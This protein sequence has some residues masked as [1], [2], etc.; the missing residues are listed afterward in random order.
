MAYTP[1]LGVTSPVNY[2]E[3]LANG[4]ASN[5]EAQQLAGEAVSRMAQGGFPIS[6]SPATPTSAGVAGQTLAC[7]GGFFFVWQDATHVK[8]VGIVNPSTP[9]AGDYGAF[10]AQNLV[11]YS[12]NHTIGDNAVYNVIF[13]L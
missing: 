1:K 4:Y 5:L 6:T 3:F 9:G 11:P 8:R 10:P 12:C 7:P 2:V 13:G